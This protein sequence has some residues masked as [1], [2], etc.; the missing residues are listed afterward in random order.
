[1]TEPVTDLAW[2]TAAK[3]YLARLGMAEWIAQ[4]RPVPSGRRYQFG[5][6]Y[7]PSEY[8]QDLIG[9]LNRND[10]HG[11]KGLKLLSGYAS[12]VGL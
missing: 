12:A 6:R 2:H 3:V 8:H 1:M 10:E 5:R 9:C 4:G 11:F 7:V